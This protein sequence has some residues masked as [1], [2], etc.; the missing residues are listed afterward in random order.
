VTP[1]VGLDGDVAPVEPV[2]SSPP[3]PERSPAA[4]SVLALVALAIGVGTPLA[5]ERTVRAVD[6]AAAVHVAWYGELDLLIEWTSVYFPGYD[7]TGQVDPWGYPF[8]S[9][10]VEYP[11]DPIGGQESGR[12]TYRAPYSRGP[13]SELGLREASIYPGAGP[14]RPPHVQALVW[15]WPLG[16]LVCAWVW[17]VGLA[18]GWPR[19]SSRA[20]EVA[21]GL[22]LGLPA[23]LL[24]AILLVS[25]IA[26]EL[27]ERVAPKTVRPDLAVAG[28]VALVGALGAVGARARAPLSAG[29]GRPGGRARRWTPWLLGLAVAVAVPHTIRCVAR[30]LDPH[31]A[32]L[33]AWVGAPCALGGH[34]PE[35]Y[36]IVKSRPEARL[37][38]WGT[39]FV[40]TDGFDESVGVYLGDRGSVC[41]RGGD[42]GEIAPG[43]ADVY[44][45]YGLDFTE[46][47]GAA[48]F[49]DARPLGVSRGLSWIDLDEAVT[50]A[51]PVWIFALA[52]RWPIGVA[53]GAW[54][55]MLGF[56]LHLPRRAP[57]PAEGALVV[58]TAAPGLLIAG[59][60][61]GTGIADSLGVQV[62]DLAITAL[63][64]LLAVGLAIA[65]RRARWR[66]RASQEAE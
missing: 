9:T 64:T 25:G 16:A 54:L 3:P 63:L 23:A 40:G 1:A 11:R 51:R 45:K 31:A 57:W 62:P 19:R 49:V 7:F 42:P 5:I 29:G 33:V 8:E 2:A 50:R 65:A 58:A 36:I 53:L 28:T 47:S 21:L 22:T 30:S 37:D 59:L 24:A 48:L 61:Y 4:R 44:A 35:R 56:A 46:S 55:A 43:P 66:A 12:A 60:A 14:A 15:R 13:P 6:P 20:A 26:E 52:W 39:P 38:P 32:V 41:S 34:L 18:T 27:G 17:S 10:T